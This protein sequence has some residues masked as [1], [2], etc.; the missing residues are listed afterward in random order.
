MQVTISIRTKN[1]AEKSMTSIPIAWISDW[2]THLLIK[3]FLIIHSALEFLEHQISIHDKKKRWIN[4]THEERRA[5]SS[6]SSFESNIERMESRSST[7]GTEIYLCLGTWIPDIPFSSSGF[8]SS[9]A[10]PWESLIGVKPSLSSREIWLWVSYLREQGR[11]DAR[12]G[13][14]TSKGLLRRAKEGKPLL[15]RIL[16][17]SMAMVGEVV[18]SEEQRGIRDEGVDPKHPARAQRWEKSHRF[19]FYF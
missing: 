12:E 16:K 5:N 11:V 18:E 7:L 13:E 9:V 4:I 10:S 8:P 6:A 19:F 3:K 17:E 2:R 14:T 1:Q 15:G